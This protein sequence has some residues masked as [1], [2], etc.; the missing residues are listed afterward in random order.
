LKKKLKTEIVEAEY[1]GLRMIKQE[2]EQ[3][4]HRFETELH[5]LIDIKSKIMELLKDGKNNHEYVEKIS[6][7]IRNA[8]DTFTKEIDYTE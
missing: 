8:I 5:E 4:T 6:S 3:L 7:R 2:V 1:I